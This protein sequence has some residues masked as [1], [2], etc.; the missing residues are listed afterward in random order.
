MKKFKIIVFC[1]LLCNLFVAC[2]SDN[3]KKAKEAYQKND[4]ATVVKQLESEENMNTGVSEMY[5]ISKAYVKYDDKNYIEALKLLLSIDTGKTHKIYGDA[6]DNLIQNAIER[7]D[8]RDVSSI[9]VKDSEIGELTAEKIIILCDNLD[10]NGFKALDSFLNV[11]EDGGLKDKL[12]DYSNDNKVKRV[13]AF[14]CGKWEWQSDTQIKTTVSNIIYEDNM[15]ATVEIVGD[16]E[17][18]YKIL[19]GDIYWKDFVFIDEKN[20]TCVS[21]CKNVYGSVAECLTT[22]K[23]DYE[24][25]T[26]N[27]HLTA[28]QP[29]IMVNPDRCWIKLP[30]N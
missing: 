30:S 3:V 23:I 6:V 12:V 21:L 22:G 8:F 16:N 5:T 28:P 19:V 17:K 27:L 4:Y 29:Y 20:F 7:V 18:E 25:N 13:K 15:L 11:A 1:L 26:V 14:L 2:D 9:I 10:Y 24:N